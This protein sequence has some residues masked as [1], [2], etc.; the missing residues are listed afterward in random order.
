MFARR[1]AP[2]EGNRQ[3]TGSRKIFFPPAR[4]PAKKPR[5]TFENSCQ[6][7]SRTAPVR[8]FAQFLNR[9]QH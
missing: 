9:F 5:G 6:E 4:C 1:A 7:Q 8:V 2:R 3:P